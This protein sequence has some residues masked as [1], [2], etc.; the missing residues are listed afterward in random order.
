MTSGTHSRPRTLKI[1]NPRF[2]RISRDPVSVGGA[3]EGRPARRK[4]VRRRPDS[5]PMSTGPVSAT[6]DSAPGM[7]RTP[8]STIASNLPPA[9]TPGVCQ[10][11]D[12]ATYTSPTATVQLTHHPRPPRQQH[13]Q[14]WT[15]LASRAAVTPNEQRLRDRDLILTSK[16]CRWPL[17][18]LF[19]NAILD[20]NA[21]CVREATVP[22]S[23]I[24]PQS[25]HVRYLNRW[26][27]P[28]QRARME[29]MEE[30][31]MLA[32]ASGT[33]WTQRSRRNQ[34]TS[35]A[36]VLSQRILRARVVGRGAPNLVCRLPFCGPPCGRSPTAQGL[37]DAF[38]ERPVVP[39]AEP[40]FGVRA[41]PTPHR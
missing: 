7:S 1:E 14:G 27:F 39:L 33:R 35:A 30:K 34:V 41:Y 25:R 19:R 15:P 29:E 3:A 4:K 38:P 2:R 32:C 12:P 6:S 9:S 23:R 20:R 8:R 22:T 24:H 36:A 10:L 16:P 31:A 11:F 5:W 28:S 13:L 26:C 40:R 18:R 17:Y 21:Q 37:T